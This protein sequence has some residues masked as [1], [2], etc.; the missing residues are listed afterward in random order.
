[1]SEGESAAVKKEVPTAVEASKRVEELPPR[2]RA[3]AHTLLKEAEKKDVG[4]RHRWIL[5]TK[6]G[7][8]EQMKAWGG[9]EPLEDKER[10]KRIGLGG[11]IGATGRAVWLDT[12]LWTMP[13]ERAELIRANNNQTL[14]DQ[15]HV[16]R[17]ETEAEFADIQGRTAAKVRPFIKAEKRETVTV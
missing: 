2:Y 10:L 6:S 8:N 17:E 5:K 14:N 9:W 11:L 13:M 1:M 15:L 7:I 16:K 3:A 4:Y 12:E